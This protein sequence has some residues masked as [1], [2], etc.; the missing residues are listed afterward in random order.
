[1]KRHT[2]HHTI[3][4]SKLY[5]SSAIGISCFFISILNFFGNVNHISGN[6]KSYTEIIADEGF[7]GGVFLLVSILVLIGFKR[8]NLMAL[9]MSFSSGALFVWGVLQSTSF[10]LYVDEIYVK[11]LTNGILAMLLG[12]IAYHMSSI[13]NALIWKE[14]VS[15]LKTES[16]ATC[17]K[18]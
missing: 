9:G 2:Q 6:K 12:A 5:I 17:I 1:M 15:A 4:K 3:Y 10:L 8:R 14:K 7:W 11:S 18:A 13:W 16:A